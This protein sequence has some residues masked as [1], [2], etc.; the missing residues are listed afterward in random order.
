VP[1]PLLWGDKTVIEERFDPRHWRITTVPRILTF[2]YPQS[3]AGIADL[4]RQTYGPTVRTF[5]ALE[6]DRRERLAA[7]LTEHWSR[8]ARSTGEMTEV[9]SEYLETVAAAAVDYARNA[10]ATNFGLLAATS[11][12]AMAGPSGVLRPCSQL[13]RVATLTPIIIANSTCVCPSCR[14]TALMS[15]AS[16][17]W[18]REG[19]ASFRRI[20]PAC[21]T[22]VTSSSN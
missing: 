19:L 18:T 16:K 7:E 21:F 13:R 17:T 12:N 11:S 15:V 6:E 14:R 3:G 8:H 1:S 10:A 5:E 9:D 2:R 22:L 4:F 20:F